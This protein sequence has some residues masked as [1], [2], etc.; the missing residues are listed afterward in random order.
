MW[1]APLLVPRRQSPLSP[2]GCLCAVPGVFSCLW[3]QSW[4]GT[5]PFLSPWR[6]WSWGLILHNP[7]MQPDVS[8]C[9]CFSGE[10]R[11]VHIESTVIKEK[12]RVSGL[13]V[14]EVNVC[15]KIFFFFKQK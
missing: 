11:L 14:V 2:H 9:V 13:Q 10:S 15:S 3:T 8:Y 4:A 5:Y 6:L 7:A 1:E 12:L